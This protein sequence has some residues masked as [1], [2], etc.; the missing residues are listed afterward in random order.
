MKKSSVLQ[1]EQ[2]KDAEKLRAMLDKLQA[3]QKLNE[4]LAEEI[5]PKT[6]IELKLEEIKLKEDGRKLA[7]KKRAKKNKQR[8]RKNERE[9][10]YHKRIRHKRWTMAAEGNWWPKVRRTWSQRGL[11]IDIT[12][13]QWNEH[14]APSIPAGVLIAVNRYD[15]KKGISLD[16]IFLTESQKSHVLWDGKEHILKIK[17]YAI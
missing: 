9:R 6:A 15:T 14:V 13:E 10:G 8:K 4:Q 12:E 17:G 7:G 2:A 11:K 1:V 3:E 16:N 5:I